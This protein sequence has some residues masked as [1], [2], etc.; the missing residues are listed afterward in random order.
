MA[1]L[2]LPGAR[3]V[4]A[5]LDGPRDGSG[6]VVACP[7]HPQYGGRRTDQRLTAVSDALTERDITCLRFDYGA[8][9]EGRGERRDA[10]TALVWARE[11][12]DH[13]AMFGYSFGAVVAARAVAHTD[14]APEGLSLLAPDAL[15]A[16]SISAISC[17]LQLIC[18]ERDDTVEWQPVRAAVEA[19]DAVVTT[20]PA[21]HHF[22]G[23]TAAIGGRVA[24]FFE[25]RL[26]D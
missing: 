19:S 7:P 16:D 3:D 5:T 13:T 23:Q 4:R 15:A 2:A 10:L 17:P 22:V 18:G 12:F 25:P 8:W 20:L 26:G 21:D 24:D 14:V 6:I 11:R 1:R 9:D